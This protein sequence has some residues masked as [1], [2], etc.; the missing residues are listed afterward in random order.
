MLLPC[1]SVRCFLRGQ[2]LSRKTCDDG[3]QFFRRLDDMSVRIVKTDNPLSPRLFVQLVNIE[4][5][6]GLQMLIES[7]HIL[8]FKI[9]FPGVASERHIVRMDERLPCFQR[10]QNDTAGQRDICAE[11]GNDVQ[12]QYIVIEWLNLLKSNAAIRGWLTVLR[13]GI[14]A[15]GGCDQPVAPLIVAWA[16]DGK[17]AGLAVRLSCPNLL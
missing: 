8:C 9:E 13:T 4:N 6:K 17:K 5:I 10:L 14:E 2:S 7:V 15:Q 3:I 12:S 1:Q 11:V 16:R